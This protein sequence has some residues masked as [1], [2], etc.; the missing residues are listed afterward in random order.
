V[1]LELM[2]CTI[3]AAGEFV[4]DHETGGLNPKL[5]I[6]NPNGQC[7]KTISRNFMNREICEICEKEQFRDL[8]V[9]RVFRGLSA[10][11]LSARSGRC[12]FRIWIPPH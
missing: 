5:E 10:P 3:D 1:A 2:L 4:E 7:Q 11:L 9:F 6:R 12:G 8:S